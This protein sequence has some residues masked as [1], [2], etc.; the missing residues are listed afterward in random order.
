MGARGYGCYYTGKWH[1]PNRRVERSFTLLPGGSGHGEQGDAGVASVA[2][3]FLHNYAEARRFFLNVGFLNPHDCCYLTFAPKNPATKFGLSDALH[4]D[5]PPAPGSFDK[6]SG[7]MSKENGKWDE[8]D[9]RL[10]NY[11]Y[12]RMVEMVD[13][14]VGRVFAEFTTRA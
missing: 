4:A 9:V 12:Y 6:C 5:L 13:A 14:E 1:V 10:Y 3:G 7:M 11:Y 2:C 8:N